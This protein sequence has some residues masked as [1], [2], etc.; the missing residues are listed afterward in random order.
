[1]PVLFCQAS[2]IRWA[3]RWDIYLKMTDT[4]IHWFSIVNSL[5]I[6]LFLSAML[7]M[8]MM[9][10][11]HRDF[12]RY[13]EVQEEDL[14]DETGW[15][16]VHGDVFRP[17]QNGGLLSIFVGSGVQILM[18]SMAALCFAVLGFLSPANRGVLMTALLL[19]FVFMGVFAGYYS[20]RVYKMFGLHSWRT[21]TL[22]TALLF[23]GFA[24]AMF[25]IL[26]LFVWGKHSSGAVPFGAMFAVL[27]LWFGISVP[28]V[29][30]GSYFGYKKDALSMPT[31]VNQIPRE[32]PTQPWYLSPA[33][34][35]L[36]GGMLPFG[37]VFVEV[38]IRYI[39]LEGTKSDYENFTTDLVLRIVRSSSSCHQSGCIDSTTCSGFSSW[40]HSSWP[41]P[42]PKSQ[43]C[44]VISNSAVKITTG[45]YSHRSALE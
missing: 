43:W 35:I 9:R 20:A 10:V 45:L 44:C 34:S 28:L 40:L 36:M 24:F 30:L 1:M 2:P 21:N 32:V 23:P 18:M 26:N 3:S 22:Y 39:L 25:F 4:K 15:K 42:V 11:L 13:N 31:K 19:L 16:L 29:Y 5:M 17:P 8:I 41:L 6:V 38:S 37:A 12:R 14:Q 7:A 33:F 27:I